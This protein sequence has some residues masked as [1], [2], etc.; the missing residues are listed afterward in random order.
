MSW[1]FKSL[2]FEYDHHHSSSASKEK[3]EPRV[4][5]PSFAV[6]S[7]F[8]VSSRHLHRVSCLP[9]PPPHLS[10]YE[11]NLDSSPGLAGVRSDLAEIG[12]SLKA[13]LR[14]VSGI[15]KLTA[16][17]FPD[18]GEDEEEDDEGGDEDYVAGIT[19]E[20][21]EFANKISGRSA[22]WTDFPLSLEADFKI[23]DSQREHASTI[24]YIVP[25]LRALRETLQGYM[26]SE[27]FWMVYFILLLPRLD[28]HDMEILSSPQAS[29]GDC[30][31]LLQ[32]VHTRNQLMQ[33]LQS[34][35]NEQAE[36]S[37]DILRTDPPESSQES[38]S[39]EEDTKASKPPIDREDAETPRPQLESPKVGGSRSVNRKKKLEYEDTISFSDVDDIDSVYSDRTSSCSRSR[40]RRDPSPG[41]SSTEWIQLNRGYES[42]GGGGS[43]RSRH[44]IKDSDAD[45]T[46]SEWVKVDESD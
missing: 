7:R 43:Q 5:S 29:L 44:S 9:I 33:K 17:F 21:V 46:A 34:S 23:T 18:N 45:S 35:K 36:T 31:I 32:I 22:C 37:E 16:K 25:S 28:E 14:A 11:T 1:L 20:V 38:N 24:E 30:S 8:P 4:E 42:R 12:G 6:G 40:G 15:S 39:S 2:Q 41:G 26:S 10:P 19:E 27:H 3:L 13:G